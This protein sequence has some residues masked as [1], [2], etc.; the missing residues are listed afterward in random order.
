M[1]YKSNVTKVPLIQPTM[2]TLNEYVE[3]ISS[4]WDTRL[5]TN[6]A[7]KHQ[8]LEQELK[9]YL[10]A[11]QLQLFVNGH[12]ALECIIEAMELKGEIITVPFTFVSTTH[13]IVRCGLK[14]VFC[15]IR[16]DTFT[17]DASKIEGLITN[18]TSAILPVHVYGMACD[19]QA[20]QQIADKH[21]L[22]VIYD[23]AHA[24]GVKFQGKGIGDFGDA[25]MYSFHA[26]KS[27]NTIEGGAL[28][29]KDEGLVQRLSALRNF[30]ITDFEQVEYVGGN[31][32]LD[33][34]RAA[35][36][37]CNLRHIANTIA[38]R[39]TAAEQYDERLRNVKGIQVL[40]EQ[41]DTTK[42]YSYYPI[43]LNEYKI[44]R[45]E[46]QEKLRSNG[47]TS[48][49]YFYP[50]CCDLACYG[51][52]YADAEVPVAR[53]IADNVLCLPMFTGITKEEVDYVCDVILN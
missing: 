22:K 19:V 10:G 27:Y 3:E 52:E 34:F 50:L 29:F 38:R 37:L 13:A 28:A 48:R 49:K 45:D 8:Q 51:D 14:P 33:E 53:H 41:A 20:I 36:G 16:K 2:P 42:V 6:M 26:T 12:H 35:M 31:S 18:K 21:G 32:K 11:E 46:L 47:I 43:V 44:T 40:G 1:A 25:S 5:L 23:A 9:T 24:F 4:I 39:K 30:G 7:S 15:D 17:M